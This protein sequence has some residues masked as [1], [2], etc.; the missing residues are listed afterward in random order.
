MDLSPEEKAGF[1]KMQAWEGTPGRGQAQGSKVPKESL[2]IEYCTRA[3]KGSVC[4]SEFT[5][6]ARRDKAG[7][8]RLN[9]IIITLKAG[10]NLRLYP[11]GH[12]RLPRREVLRTTVSFRNKQW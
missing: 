2:S 1:G 11:V 5:K 9:Q 10:L 12:G 3:K 8:D 7:G 6:D 4:T